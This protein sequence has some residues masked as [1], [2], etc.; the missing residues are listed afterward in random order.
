MTD[1]TTLAGL[2]EKYGPLGMCLILMG[3]GLVYSLKWLRGE[4]EKNREERK[5]ELQRAAQERKEA[6]DKFSS[7]LD[8]IG[9]RYERMMNTAVDKFDKSLEKQGVRIDALADRVDK[10]DDHLRRG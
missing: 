2:W 4:Q 6:H 3:A 10:L 9:S 1:V 7:Q 8:A 5:E